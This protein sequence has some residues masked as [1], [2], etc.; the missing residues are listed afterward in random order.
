MKFEDHQ[1]RKLTKKDESDSYRAIHSGELDVLQPFT[2]KFYGS[3]LYEESQDITG[4][5]E[6]NKPDHVALPQYTVRLENLLNGR[7]SGSII[8]LKM[9]KTITSE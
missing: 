4:L 2:C 1:I 3:D 7:Q 8:D 9:G 6:R 5:F